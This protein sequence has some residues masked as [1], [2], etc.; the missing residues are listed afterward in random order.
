M[1][2]KYLIFAL[3]IVIFLI[4]IFSFVFYFPNT[5]K[6]TYTS[7]NCHI[8]CKDKGYEGGQCDWPDSI[9]K[10]FPIWKDIKNIGN[11]EADTSNHCSGGNCDCICYNNNWDYINVTFRTNLEIGKE[12]NENTWIALDTD[13]DK[14][15]EGWCYSGDNETMSE[16]YLR[17]S[18]KAWYALNQT[19]SIYVNRDN[20]FPFLKVNTNGKDSIKEFYKPCSTAE[21]SIKTKE[22]YKSNNQETY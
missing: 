9:E 4:L 7:G 20:H 18:F 19:I 6:G 1:K 17:A 8:N 13:G 12:V 22:P 10:T 16:E 5:K 15:L 3:V 21:T 14:N 2:N 11:C